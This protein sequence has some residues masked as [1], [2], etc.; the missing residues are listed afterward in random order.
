MT[1]IELLVFVRPAL[2]VAS[3]LIEFTPQ[4][5][6]T[7][8]QNVLDTERTQFQQQDTLAQSEG[9]VT[10][11]LIDD[12]KRKNNVETLRTRLLEMME[13]T[14]DPLLETF[15]KRLRPAP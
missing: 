5:R 8:F 6:L 7:N 13:R 10:Q 15:K 14:R 4:L 1:V 11:N 3:A 12:P 9:S 2:S